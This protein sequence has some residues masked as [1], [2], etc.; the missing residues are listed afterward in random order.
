MVGT[1]KRGFCQSFRYKFNVSLA[2]DHLKNLNGAPKPT[3]RSAD[4]ALHLDPQTPTALV[5]PER[6]LHR[7]TS[8]LSPLRSDTESLRSRDNTTPTNLDLSSS[9]QQDSSPCD[10][11][12][13]SA[14]DHQTDHVLAARD[15]NMSSNAYSKSHPDTYAQEHEREIVHLLNY[16]A[17]KVA[18]VI[19][20]GILFL[21]GAPG[22][23][24]LIFVVGDGIKEG[25][26]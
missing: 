22:L 3:Q 20:S 5:P 13:L 6:V 24:V 18:L 23:V 4:S 21:I 8:F 11:P 14:Q 19:Y 26:L 15:T 2:D 16:K 10:A 7:S 1:R 9:G 25:Y 17:L 12:T